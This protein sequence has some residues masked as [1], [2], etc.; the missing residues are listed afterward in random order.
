MPPRPVSPGPLIAPLLLKSKK[1]VPATDEELTLTPPELLLLAGLTS[2]DDVVTDAELVKL[3]GRLVTV[4]ISTGT[5]MLTTAPL[6]IVPRSQ[7][8]D[9]PP[10]TPVQA[11][12]VALPDATAAVGAPASCMLAGKVSLTSTL[13]ASSS[14]SPV[15]LR[16]MMTKSNTSRTLT[17]LAEGILLTTSG[18]ALVRTVVF[19]LSASF[20]PSVS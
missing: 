13:S 15:L 9:V 5:V 6:D 8:N 2:S 10:E 12:A 3:C 1:T 7:E 17:G 16:T 11:V 14:P 18:S 4:V 19:S 20:N